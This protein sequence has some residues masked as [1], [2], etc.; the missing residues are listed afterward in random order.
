MFVDE[1]CIYYLEIIEM[2]IM[3]LRLLILL[4]FEVFSDGVIKITLNFVYIYF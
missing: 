3:I 1:F 4:V 2:E